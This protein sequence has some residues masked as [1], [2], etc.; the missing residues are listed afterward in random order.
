MLNNIPRTD[1]EEI[2]KKYN[3]LRNYAEVGELFSITRQRVHQI[4]TGYR[5]LAY[6]LKYKIRRKG[7]KN[8]FATLIRELK[9]K[10]CH[11]CNGKTQAT[12][13][14]DGNPKN[15]TKDNLLPVC[16][17]CHGILHRGLDHKGKY[18]G[19]LCAFCN[20]ALPKKSY[21][22]KHGRFCSSI[23]RGHFKNPERKFGRRNALNC[24]DCGSFKVA[25][26]DRCR[27]HYLYWL[28]HNYPGRKEKM[29]ISQKKYYNKRKLLK[30]GMV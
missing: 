2:R 6:H 15:N 27:K 9:A 7:Q 23:C 22:R 18:D 17:K 13:H 1:K 28:Y 10:P 3:E 8:S 24:I 12:H 21:Y 4:I 20:K 5:S 16:R 19:Q 29:A 25:S 30:L 14:L 26:R 11:N